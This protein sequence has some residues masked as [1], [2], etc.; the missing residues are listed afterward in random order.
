[1]DLDDRYVFC[2]D[3]QLTSAMLF[4]GA[5][6]TEVSVVRKGLVLELLQ[7]QK[8][9]TAPWSQF[10]LW[11]EKLFQAENVSINALRKSVT[12][13]RSKKL[14]IQKMRHVNQR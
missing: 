9:S 13:L 12:D 14:K 2:K 10:T 6:F 5:D 7:I 11:I 1:M 4:D 3:A 8:S